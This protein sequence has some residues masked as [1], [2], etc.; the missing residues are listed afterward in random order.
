[1]LVPGEEKTLHQLQLQRAR[2]NKERKGGYCCCQAE[3]GK[4]SDRLLDWTPPPRPEGRGRVIPQ[5]GEQR[6]AAWK[7]SQV[8]GSFLITSNSV[9]LFNVKVQHTEL[10]RGIFFVK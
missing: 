4:C 9:L 7:A 2:S 5:V 8:D 10:E 3:R 1:M 6:G